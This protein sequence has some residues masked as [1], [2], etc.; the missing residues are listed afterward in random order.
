MFFSH[1]FHFYLL[2][3]FVLIIILAFCVYSSTDCYSLWLSYK[4]CLQF[5]NFSAINNALH[6]LETLKKYSFWPSK[7]MWV[8]RRLWQ[9]NLISCTICCLSLVPYNLSPHLCWLAQDVP[10]SL[11]H[12][13]FFV[14]FIVNN[15]FGYVCQTNFWQCLLWNMGTFINPVIMFLFLQQSHMHLHQHKITF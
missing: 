6:I 12:T 5:V 8:W 11:Q 13:L 15:E 7:R 2:G 9:I 14:Y 1:F 4:N 3:F 10:C